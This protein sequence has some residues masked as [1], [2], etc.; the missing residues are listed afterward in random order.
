MN[1]RLG[2]V[3][4]N[5]DLVDCS[6]SGTVTL[7]AL[8]KIPDER[9][10]IHKLQKTAK[11]NLENT[12]RILKYNKAMN[13]S[14]YRLT[15]K[16]IP[17]ATHPMLRDWD[18]ISDFR[19]ELKGIG[20]F[21]LENKMRV[22]AHPDHYTLLNAISDKVLE[23]SLIDLDYHVRLFEGM[24]LDEAYKLVLHIG[25]VYKDK[26]TST[27][28]FR[29]NFDRLPD[30]IK[31]RIIL[32]NDD[33]SYA[34]AEVLEICQ[35]ARI[36]MV[37]DVHHL[38]CNNQGESLI[39]LWPEILDTWNKERFRPKIHFSSPKSC[40]EFRSHSEFIQEAEF[41]DFLCKVKTID[42]DFDVMLEAKAKSNALLKLSEELSTMKRLTRMNIGEF[43]ME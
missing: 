15:S 37:L 12:L 42:R 24:G 21:I 9:V 13:I 38:Q 32:E 17:L 23:D 2:Y 29:E 30:R 1:F 36:P 5:M 34:A 3:A 18:Y 40:K 16:L 31:K 43:V 4:M 26:K 39:E 8:N 7:T 35:S 6:P 20:D 19:Q 28:K 14:V 10:R 11:K 22:S 25:G 33:K 27:E 41:Y